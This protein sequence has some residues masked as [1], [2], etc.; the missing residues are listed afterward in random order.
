MVLLLAA[1]GPAVG[2]SQW[3]TFLEAAAT[4]ALAVSTRSSAEAKVCVTNRLARTAAVV[5][6][7]VFKRMIVP[8]FGCLVSLGL[9]A[10]CRCGSAPPL[11]IPRDTNGDQQRHAVEQ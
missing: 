6:S 7:V 9:G 11:R 10:R 4:L 3:S 8:P 1:F 2:P 5:K